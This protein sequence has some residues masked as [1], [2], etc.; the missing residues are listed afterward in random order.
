MGKSS[1]VIR[2]T[3]GNF[4]PGIQNTIGVAYYASKIIVDDVEVKLQVSTSCNILTLIFL[5]ASLVNSY[6]LNR[7]KNMSTVTF[8]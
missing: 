1:I 2:Y 8:I 6:L 5:Y 4:S 3:S 7:I